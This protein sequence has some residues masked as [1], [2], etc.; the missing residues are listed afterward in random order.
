VEN[1][2]EK[3]TCQP[4]DLTHSGQTGPTWDKRKPA[5]SHQKTEGLNKDSSKDNSKGNPQQKTQGI[6]LRRRP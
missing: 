2:T 1:W 3:E 5:E 4:E 6:V